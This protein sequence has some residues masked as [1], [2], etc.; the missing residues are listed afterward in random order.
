MLS[1]PLEKHTRLQAWVTVVFGVTAASFF[2][3]WSMQAEHLRAHQRDEVCWSVL[4]SLGP[5]FSDVHPQ[6]SSHPKCVV[7]G[8]VRTEADRQLL[9]SRLNEAFTPEER[10]LVVSFVRVDATTDPASQ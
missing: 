1:V 4:R 8:T 2:L 6:V 10:R 7:L 9:E 3:L 5:S